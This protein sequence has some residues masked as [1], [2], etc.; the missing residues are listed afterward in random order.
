[1]LLGMESG[2]TIGKIVLD[3]IE[4]WCTESDKWFAAHRRRRWAKTSGRDNIIVNQ[5][6]AL[7]GR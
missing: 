4:S 2:R 3:G 5:G 7:A 1:M 6:L